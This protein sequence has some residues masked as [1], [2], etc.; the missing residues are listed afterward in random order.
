MTAEDGVFFG[1]SCVFT[2]D[3]RPR[4]FLRRD[5]KNWLTPTHLCQGCSIGANVTV[6]CGVTIGQFS[7]IGAGSLITKNVPPHALIVGHNRLIGYVCRCGET[8]QEANKNFVCHACE[9]VTVQAEAS[10]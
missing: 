5:K 8:L 4:S 9:Q 7:M 10:T 3:K 6:M 2:N 1:P